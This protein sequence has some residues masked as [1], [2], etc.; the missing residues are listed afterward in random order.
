ML[1]EKEA[2]H[3]FNRVDDSNSKVVFGAMLFVVASSIIVPF[4][5]GQGAAAIV[6]LFN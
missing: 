5:L 2:L 6:R 1:V 4:F 3:M